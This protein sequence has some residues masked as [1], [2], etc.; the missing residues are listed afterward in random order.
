M[1]TVRAGLHTPL[2]L[3]TSLHD[4]N[5]RHDGK[6]A[7]MSE[8][9]RL[10]AKRPD[11]LDELRAAIHPAERSPE[12]VA[13][14]LR[15]TGMAL[16]RNALTAKQLEDW[17]HFTQVGYEV[18]DR[19]HPGP[20]PAESLPLSALFAPHSLENGRREF[21][22]MCLDARFMDLL[23]LYFGELPFVRDGHAAF[24]RLSRPVKLPIEP[25]PPAGQLTLWLPLM[26]SGGR[27]LGYEV[28]WRDGHWRPNMLPGDALLL[29][30]DRPPRVAGPPAAQGP[31]LLDG[32]ILGAEIHLI[33]NSA[34]RPDL[35]QMIALGHFPDFRMETGF[36]RERP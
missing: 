32:P 6:S 11:G 1:E 21:G 36:D 34:R 26:A 7:P 22:R 10:P 30:G 35:G 5:P 20:K 15:E 28:P 9:T 19:D 24:R 27:Q 2:A 13:N 18:W 33:G 17:R 23:R 16:L 8:T 31:L 25:S 12:A 3:V 29:S 4:G 14:A